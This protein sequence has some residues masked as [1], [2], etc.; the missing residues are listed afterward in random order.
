[1]SVLNFRPNIYFILNINWFAKI[2]VDNSFF[3]SI[4]M[5]INGKHGLPGE[6]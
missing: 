3:L 4:I 6:F 2:Q 5:M 1:M